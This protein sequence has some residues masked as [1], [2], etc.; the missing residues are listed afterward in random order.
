MPSASIFLTKVRSPAGKAAAQLLIDCLRAFGGEMRDCPI[1]VFATDPQVE[2]CQGLAGSQVEVFHLPTPETVKQYPFGDKVFACAFAEA[3]APAG[4]QSLIWLDLECLVIQPPLLYALGDGFDAA[5]RPV[6]LR[7]VGLPPEEP[8]NAFWKGIYDAAG[9]Q[10]VQRTVESFVDQQRLRAYFNSHGFSIRPTLGLCSR[11]FE[12]FEQLVCN[13][14]FQETA[15]RE[16]RHQV[17]LFQALLSALLV[18]CLD[19]NRIRI[20]PPAY[21]YPYN[22]QGQIGKDR[23][24]GVL[25]DLVSFTFEGRTIHPKSVTDIEIRA[26]LR[27][28]LEAR[29]K[30]ELQSN[31]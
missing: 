26:P 3:R 19:E 22:L 20:L 23:R 30:D 29:V 11:W 21:N 16:E 17:F 24:A 12:L 18:S 31:G 25:N 10:D 4:T 14:R 13:R 28:W 7:N 15:C 2:S 5:L 27:T 1:W 8:L 6:H 9:I